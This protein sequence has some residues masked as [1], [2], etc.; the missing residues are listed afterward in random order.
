MVN[1]RRS[2]HITNHKKLHITIDKDLVCILTGA[3]PYKW[4]VFKGAKGTFTSLTKVWKFQHIKWNLWYENSPSSVDTWSYTSK[5]NPEIFLVSAKCFFMHNSKGYGTSALH[6]CWSA[7]SRSRRNGPD[8]VETISSIGGGT[9]RHPG[10][11]SVSTTWGEWSLRRERGGR[12]VSGCMT[13]LGGCR[14]RQNV[15]WCWSWRS[16]IGLWA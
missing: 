9:G 12:V 13:T 10:W 11:N 15:R 14:R 2:V 4:R 1:R 3:G 5:H 16:R 7:W 8:G 6:W